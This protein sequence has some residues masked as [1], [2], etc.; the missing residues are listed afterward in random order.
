MALRKNKMSCL[1]TANVG[2]N[3]ANQLQQ[4]YHLR[5]ETDLW[6]TSWNDGRRLFLQLSGNRIPETPFGGSRMASDMTLTI[7]NETR[8]RS[9]LGYLLLV[10][11]PEYDQVSFSKTSLTSSLS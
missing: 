9:L 8:G 10:A 1:W 2:A 7:G 11:V 4:L 3:R 5:S 6:E